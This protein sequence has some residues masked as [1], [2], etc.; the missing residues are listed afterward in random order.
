MKTNTAI[1]VVNKLTKK[2]KH[3]IFW[4]DKKQLILFGGKISILNYASLKLKQW[5]P[6]N[7]AFKL[8]SYE[9]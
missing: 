2:K 6:N 7:N 4:L 8:V 5:D 1:E 3:S 9:K